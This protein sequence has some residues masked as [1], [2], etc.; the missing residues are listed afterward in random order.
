[1]F[2]DNLGKGKAT[3]AAH[4]HGAAL[5]EARWAVGGL[6]VRAVAEVNEARSL[7]TRHRRDEARGIAAAH[8]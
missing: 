6:R 7:S 4:I 2:F 1:M 5:E 3:G 8:A